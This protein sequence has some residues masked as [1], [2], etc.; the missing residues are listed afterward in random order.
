MGDHLGSVTSVTSGG[1]GG[2]SEERDSYDAWGKRRNA[3]ATDDPGCTESSVLTR[4][5]TEHE[6]LD[7]FC[8]VNMNARLY[9]PGLGLFLSADSV[10]PQ[11]YD[12]SGYMRYSYVGNNPLNA[13]DPSGHTIVVNEYVVVTGI[14]YKPCAEGCGDPGGYGLGGGGM[15][16][17]FNDPGSGGGGRGLG[18]KNKNKN[19][20]SVNAQGN[21]IDSYGNECV[22][23]TGEP[24]HPPTYTTL[25]P[26]IL[27]P[28]I[29]MLHFDFPQDGD[30]VGQIDLSP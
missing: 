14:P 10:V 21:I 30:D 6:M 28:Q 12:F 15:G 9:D 22:I 17:G 26:P 24:W 11:P 3:D 13:T 20:C 1:I 18:D 23:N 29:P 27:A 19:D 4:G 25:L 8:L 16:G 7:Q 2:A 5:F